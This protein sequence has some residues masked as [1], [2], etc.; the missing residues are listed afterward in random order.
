MKTARHGDLLF[1]T[2]SKLPKECRKLSEGINNILALGEFTGHKHVLVSAEPITVLELDGEKFFEVKDGAEVTHDEH[3]T[4]KLLP[5][6]YRMTVE[7]EFD[8]FLQESR[9]V[10]D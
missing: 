1:R 7:K 4:I 9:K 8:Y 10:V 6:I 3:K 5:G 2:I